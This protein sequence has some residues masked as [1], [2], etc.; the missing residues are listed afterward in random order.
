M[1][2]SD[3]EEM[4]EIVYIDNTSDDDS[5][6]EQM[7]HENAIYDNYDNFIENFTSESNQQFIK[8]VWGFMLSDE[9]FPINF[10]T[11]TNL[12]HKPMCNSN[13]IYIGFN[14]FCP[15]INLIQK[16]GDNYKALVPYTG[17]SI[18]R[19]KNSISYYDVYETLH[20]RK[21][22]DKILKCCPH[23]HCYIKSIEHRGNNIYDIRFKNNEEYEEREREYNRM[24]KRMAE[25]KDPYASDDII[26]FEKLSLNTQF[27][28]DNK[29][30]YKFV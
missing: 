3:D 13:L 4:N 15:H 26:N 30:T 24:L 29:T 7:G 23:C 20:N 25:N 19:K 27:Q 9:V 14:R 6:D 18:F 16:Y 8:N 22:R 1:S 17:I 2:F 11:Y 12:I 10:M 28:W 21:N 5:Y